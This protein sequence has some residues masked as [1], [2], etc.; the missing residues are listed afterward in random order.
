MQAIEHS[1]NSLIH[2][3]VQAGLACLSLQRAER[4]QPTGPIYAAVDPIV[5]A[6][7]VVG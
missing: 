1:L 3:L 5:L 7:L 6:A 2:K 4:V